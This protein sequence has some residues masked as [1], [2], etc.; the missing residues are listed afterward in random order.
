M[1]LSQGLRPSLITGLWPRGEGGWGCLVGLLAA[2][3]LLGAGAEGY[4]HRAA[5]LV[6]RPVLSAGFPLALGLGRPG[7]RPSSLVL[8]GRVTLTLLLAHLRPPF[9]RQRID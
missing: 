2:P 7:F 3:V 5:A 1:A 9:L 8:L 4:L 6:E